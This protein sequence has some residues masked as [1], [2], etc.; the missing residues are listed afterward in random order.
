MSESVVATQQ[1]R[2]TKGAGVTVKTHRGRTGGIAALAVALLATAGLALAQTDTTRMIVPFAA[3]GPADQIARVVAPALAAQLGKPVIIENRGGAGG[4]IGVTAAVNAAPNGST[5]LLTTSSLVITAGITPNLAYDPRRDLEPVYLLG[6]V[7]TML[8]VRNS[9]G[10]RSLAELIEKA[11]Q[12]QRLNYGSTGVGGT[13]HIGA[14]LFSKAA[15]VP[16][17]HIPYKG[18]A[19]ALVDLMAGT[20]DLVNA[21][22]PVLRGYIKDGRLTPIVIYDTRRSDQLPDVP[23]AVEAGMPALQMSNWYGVLAPA[24]TP[25]EVLRNIEAAFGRVLAQPE[26]SSRLTEA[27]FVNPRN[28][29]GFKTKLA[30][31]FE[32]WLPW[33]KS[34]NI[35]A[36]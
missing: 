21:D 3:G 13:M 2:T 24:G 18:A 6:E 16:M 25:A 11:R 15:N 8:A 1:T 14:E 9:L 7:Q 29:A 10:V 20:I 19:P 31:D 35:R 5:L 33:L 30:G 28:A 23:T 36:D 22:V 34:A 32:R 17:V 27:G 4:V 12:P 26:I